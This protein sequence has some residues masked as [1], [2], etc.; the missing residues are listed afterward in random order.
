MFGHDKADDNTDPQVM[1]PTEPVQSDADDTTEL[2]LPAPD[3]ITTDPVVA[4]DSPV[5]DEPAA[6]A[7]EPA[8][9]EPAV[10]ET[11]PETTEEPVEPEAE[12]E[13]APAEDTEAVEAATAAVSIGGSSMG[14]S[15]D[16]ASLKEE[17][18]KE[19]SPLVA[20]LDQPP[21]E[22]LKTIMKIYEATNDQ[23][24]LKEAHEAA[25]ALSDDTARAKAL[26]DLVQK[27][28]EASA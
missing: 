4:S 17:A 20:H 24:L 5:A 13:E 19:L 7:D 6:A 15:S 11:A 27:I 26:L 28:D 10:A 18:L 14:G 8:T 12:A 25:I 9:E 23:T 3:P 2:T 1:T 22:K 16:L 21:E